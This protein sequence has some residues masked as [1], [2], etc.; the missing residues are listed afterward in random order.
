[1]NTFDEHTAKKLRDST[2]I[3]TPK[4]AGTKQEW[5]P[6]CE[7]RM[8]QGSRIGESSHLQQVVTGCD[9]PLDIPTENR[10]T[11]AAHE[12]RARG[13]MGACCLEDGPLLRNAASD[14]L[15]ASYPFSAPP[16]SKPALALC[17]QYVLRTSPRFPETTKADRL[18]CHLTFGIETLQAEITFILLS[19]QKGS[20]SR[21]STLY[22]DDPKIHSFPRSSVGTHMAST[23]NRRPYAFPRRTVGTSRNRRLASPSYM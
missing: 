4:Q 13:V 8:R 1:M 12:E 2:Q 17:R 6:K 18:F 14:E 5:G 10:D 15:Y 16:R 3:P 9:Y 21:S 22:P 11:E 20:T 19:C 23:H 7:T